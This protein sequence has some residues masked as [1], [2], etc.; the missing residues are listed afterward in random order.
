MS[1]IDIGSTLEGFQRAETPLELSQVFS[2]LITSRGAVGYV[3][4]SHHVSD[5]ADILMF[6]SMPE[7]FGELDET[8]AWWDD[9]PL[10][11]RIDTGDLTPFGF[12]EELPS[13][14]PYAAMR[15][16]VM[17]ESGLGFG[18]VLPTTGGGRFGGISVFA[19]QLSDA[20]E[21]ITAHEKPFQLLSVAFQ[22]FL[23]SFE[24][25]GRPDGQ[26]ILRD[27]SAIC[28][29]AELPVDGAQIPRL[30]PRE[31]DC[32]S[33]CAHGKSAYET[34]VILGISVYTVRFHLRGALAKLGA[35]SQ[36]QAVAIAMRR[37]EIR[38]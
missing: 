17:R 1:R 24:E 28:R 2:K 37:G 16:D 19:Q 18:R 29:P 5:R 3:G 26:V 8:G 9:D 4:T 38:L 21:E 25:L 12:Q 35:R 34:S 10:I 32:L 33:W 6:T 11:D 14:S 36:A 20:E 31:V 27:G 22:G 30:S 23:T 7:L 15:F 13:A